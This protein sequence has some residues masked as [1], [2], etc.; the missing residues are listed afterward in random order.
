MAKK[1][2]LIFGLVGFPV[3][4][5]FSPAMHNAAF[6]ALDI[7]A[8][9]KVMPDLKI[10]AYGYLIED[11][12]NTLGLRVKGKV[13]TELPILYGIEYAIQKD[14]SL[15]SILGSDINSQYYRVDLGT[16]VDNFFVK[17]YLE[18]LGEAQGSA[19]SGFATPLATLHKF[20]GWSDVML[21]TASN[22]SS[23][24]LKDLA[25]T[26][27]YKLKRG[28]VFATYHKFD[29]VTNS[30][31]YGSE[32]DLAYGRTILDNV[33]LLVKAALY[34]KGSNTTQDVTKYWAMI[35]TNI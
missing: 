26:V 18:V 23:N 8:K 13:K 10:K 34:Q 20:N 29:S 32:F 31:D 27:G 3:K 7:N 4:H 33:K 11:A 6:K 28:K 19:A 35:S 21:A 30:L 12:H 24:G 5:S 9:Y 25:F 14:T 2:P 16:N 22:G 1:N 15:K 17:G